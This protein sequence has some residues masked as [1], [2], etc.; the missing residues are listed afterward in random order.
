MEGTDEF[1]ELL[2]AREAELQSFQPASRETEA[3]RTGDL[4]FVDCITTEKS[5]ICG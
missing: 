5:L 3:D 1:E 4:K 2:E